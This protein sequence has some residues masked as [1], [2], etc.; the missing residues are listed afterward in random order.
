[1][2]YPPHNVCFPQT[3]DIN[4]ASSRRWQLFLPIFLLAEEAAVDD[5]EIRIGDRTI[6]S[7]HNGTDLRLVGNAHPTGY[8]GFRQFGL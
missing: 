3:C 7:N 8:Q 2:R 4:R 6:K 1:M 5:M